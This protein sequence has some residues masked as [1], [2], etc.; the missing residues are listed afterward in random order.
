MPDDGRFSKSVRHFSPRPLFSYLQKLRPIETSSVLTM[1]IRIL[2]MPSIPPYSRSEKLEDYAQICHPIKWEEEQIKASDGTRLSIITSD[3]EVGSRSTRPGVA[4]DNR[5]L[6]LYFQGYGIY[7]FP[8][9]G[10]YSNEYRNASSLP[11]RTPHLADTMKAVSRLAS[12]GHPSIL[13]LVG[14]SYRGY[15][16]SRGRPSQRGI[17]LDAAATLDWAAK[18][19]SSTPN[20]NIVLWG[21]SIGAG[22]VTTAAAKYQEVRAMESAPVNGS[23]IIKALILETPFTNLSDLLRDFYPQRWL[24]YRYL[25]PFLIS[26]WDSKLAL[27]RIAQTQSNKKPKVFI[28][29]AG[30]DEVVPGKHGEELEEWC[31]IHSLDLEIKSIRGA[32][33]TDKSPAGR[34]AIARYLV[35]FL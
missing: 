1:G 17:E 5:L 33:H 22:V 25:T 14:V 27:Q 11:P 18:K 32:L 9:N 31:K 16:K 12:S 26:R 2:Y 20:L 7:I 30:K 34:E 29:Q 6:V 10:S 24:P 35:N 4:E 13:S 3:I 19:Y 15:W 21:E 28:L 8:F 23:P